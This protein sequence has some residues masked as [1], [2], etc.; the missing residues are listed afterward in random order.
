MT[1][2]RP[3][4]SATV[5][6]AANPLDAVRAASAAIEQEFRA[7]R[8]PETVRGRRTSLVDEAVTEAW[9]RH[10]HPVA[11][12]GLSVLAVGGYGRRDLFPHSDIDLLV[13]VN[14]PPVGSAKEGLSRFL[15]TLWDAT[16]RVSH[17][18]RTV[19]ECCEMH[20]HNVELN[21]S[22]LDER[23]LCGDDVLHSELSARLPRFLGAQ[24]ST[25]ARHL[26]RLSH[27]RHSKYASTIHHLEPNIKESPGGMR[28]L[29]LIAWLDKLWETAVGQEPEVVEAMSFLAAT[30]CFL[31][32]RSNR[33][34]NQLSFDAQ[35]EIAADPAS[36][37]RR[38]YRHT[39]TVYRAALRSV[40]AFESKGNSLVAGFR[41][42]R[43]RLS[44]SEFTVS[45]DRILFRSSQQLT[46][47][48]AL[49]MRLFAFAGRH[50]VPLHSETERRVRDNLGSL[51]EHYGQNPGFWAELREVLNLPHASSALR[52]MHD[53]GFLGAV[54]PDWAGIE[55]Y[56]VRDF[57]HRYTVD[58]HTLI[59]IE[60]LE[61]LREG[62]KSVSALEERFRTLLSEIDDP[63]TLLFA[64]VFHDTGKGA[65]DSAHAAQSAR[66]AAAA[67]RRIGMPE[68]T[69]RIVTSLVDNHLVLSSAMTGRDLDDPATAQ[70]LADRV[71]FVEILKH[72][73]L[74]TFAD[75][76]AVHP[77]ALT[78]WRMEQLWRVHRTAERELTRELE[79]DRIQSQA[80]LDMRR[81]QFL[82]G[83]PTRYLRTRTDEDIQYHLGLED[84]RQEAGVALDIRKR[85]GVYELTVLA[86]DRLALFSSIAGALAGF[87]MNILKAE[88]FA[89]Q[90]GTVLDTFSFADPQRTLELNPPEMD[91]L[92]QI[93]ERVLLGRADVKALL[94]NRPRPPA[95]S[96]GSRFDPRVSFD[97]DASEVATLVEVVA[98]DRP[99]LLYDLTSAFTEAGCN[100]D[101]VLIDTEAHR[102]LDVFYVNTDS[103]KLPSA[104]CVELETALLRACAG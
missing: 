83:F 54:F 6:V 29:H 45:R 28:D 30:R 84:V 9:R 53:T 43:S 74:L 31:H 79:R 37:M 40:D 87:G 73:T 102:A 44:S 5:P 35:E 56:V 16:L 14:E 2:E 60:R 89:N 65:E 69:V 21:I 49:A 13:L 36:F 38:Y 3:L 72:L 92:R 58:E 90:Q 103:R 88:A 95:P 11:P 62:G 96:R 7:T 12:T 86:K 25:L 51:V 104:L 81:Q 100:I 99:G 97:N 17:S 23:F 22:L 55:C 27:Q 76:S 42:W 85:E 18:V 20:D 26:C 80:S 70:W 24:R 101:V 61:Q 52:A 46:H 91:R 64:L 77:G 71:G 50:R 59:A 68:Q 94:K 41:D 66:L 39:R 98:Q 75:T 1:V 57:N 63:A 47:D 32:Y 34:N 67:A 19:R 10:L 48:P 4:S 93:V 82:K 33:D 78:P 15:Q 8:D